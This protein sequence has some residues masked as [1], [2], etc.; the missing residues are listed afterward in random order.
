MSKG[1]GALAVSKPI[2]AAEAAER[3][4]I[5]RTTLL[6]Y[7]IAGELPFAYKMPGL[8]GSYLFDP[9]VVAVFARSRRNGRPGKK[10]S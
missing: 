5:S 3:L 1:S 8:R 4:G 10:A 6:R 9:D 7:V 2:T